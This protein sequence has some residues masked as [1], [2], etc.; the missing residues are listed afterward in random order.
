M[1][2]ESILRKIQRCLALSTSDNPNEAATAL[3]QAQALMAKHGVSQLD[4]KRAELGEATLKSKMSVS[5][6][7]DWE[8]HLLATVG[9]AF[10]CK[11]MFRPVTSLDYKVRGTMGTY[12]YLGLKQQAELAQYTA[13]V[14]LRRLIKARVNYTRKLPSYLERKEKTEL[15]DGFCV[16]WAVKIADKVIEF[17]LPNATRELIEAE[18]ARQTKGREVTR[19]DTLEL[20][21]YHDGVAAAADETLHRPVHEQ[22]QTLLER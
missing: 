13:E 7:K 10:G 1:V 14:L 15:A 19:R 12:V 17:A 11:L 21:G 6:P 8:I 18:Y 20:A 2:D 3:R 16:G 4:V 5:K 22:K 9:K